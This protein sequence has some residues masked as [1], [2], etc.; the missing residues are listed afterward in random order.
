MIPYG[1][2][3]INDEDIDAV[4]KTLKSELITQGLAVPKFEANLCRYTGSKFSVVTS[5]ATSA[6]HIACLALGLKKDDIVWT[7][8]ITF[9]ASAN[10]ARYCGAKIDFV[11]VEPETGLMSVTC[12]REKLEHAERKGLL[13][14]IVIPV[15]LAGQPCDM[16]E[17]HSLSIKYDFKIIEDAA[18]AVGAKY[19]NSN[20]G[21]CVFSDITVF[22][23]HP[24]KIITTGEGG[25]AMTNSTVLDSK[26]KLLR[27]HGVTRDTKLMSKK[28]GPW[29]YEQVCLGYHYR[30]T[31]I[32]AALGV[33]QLKRLGKFIAKRRKIFDWYSERI[34]NSSIGERFNVLNQKPDRESSH[35]LFI[36]QLKKDGNNANIHQQM[37]D[38]GV[39]VN[40]HYIP[41][42]KH[43]NFENQESLV[44][45]EIYYKRSMSLPIFPTISNHERNKVADC[46]EKILV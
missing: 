34:K 29:Y 7:S 44:G 28:D 1:R 14:K 24:V 16:K 23:F 41:V 33:S 2:Q 22:S 12:L 38:M 25:A 32:N 5:S 46:L 21:N 35:H 43:P 36:V 9:V 27:S 40:L 30:M 10:C 18:H 15:H 17:I 11:D 20:I 6:L 37:I 31:D 39:G 3:E 13:P 42:Y 8:P 26:M 19:L 45:A 4:V